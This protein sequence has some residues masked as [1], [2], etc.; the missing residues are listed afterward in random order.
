MVNLSK[1]VSGA[2][3][4]A[5]KLTTSLQATVIWKAWTGNDQWG[6]KIYTTHSIRALVEQEVR[7]ELDQATGQAIQTRA[8]I[9]ILEPLPLVT[10]AGRINPIDNRDILILPDG[11]TGPAYMPGG[12]VN[13]ETSKPF[14][15]E[16]WMGSQSK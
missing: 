7:T 8:K 6:R 9:T 16:V 2:V 5:S 11:T 15:M 13:P 10:A 14:L 4:T 1:I 3:K 12:F